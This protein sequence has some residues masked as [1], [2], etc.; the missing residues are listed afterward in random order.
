LDGIINAEEKRSSQLERARDAK[1]NLLG[2]HDQSQLG[3]G[4]AGGISALSPSKSAVASS[5]S[6]QEAMKELAD[7]KALEKRLE[8]DER[9]RAKE[10]LNKKGDDAHKIVLMPKYKLD[11]RLNV[12]KE[13]DP[14]PSNMFIGLG[15]DEDNTTKRRHYRQFY[16]D[17]LENNKDLFP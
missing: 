1:K 10:E 11:E 8:E 17:E 9:L 4:M 6:K 16:S 15:W 3:A 14:P 13:F 2:M 5:L 12:Y 7:A